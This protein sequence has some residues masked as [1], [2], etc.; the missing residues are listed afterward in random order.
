MIGLNVRQATTLG[1]T[2]ALGGKFRDLR[3]RKEVNYTQQDAKDIIDRN[4][5]DENAAYMRLAERL[6]LQQ[7][8]A[9]SS[10]AAIRASTPEQG[11]VLTFKRA[12]LVD[13]WADLKIGLEAKAVKAASSA[14][15][16]LILACTIMLLAVFGWIGIKAVRA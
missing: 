10:P 16:I 7:D 9:V 3:G 13:T 11:R 14:V 6:V 12:V 5:A 15:R 2:A 4:S 1:D 8:A